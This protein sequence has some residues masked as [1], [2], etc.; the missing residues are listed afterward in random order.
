MYFAFILSER[1]TIAFSEEV[2]KV[3]EVYN[4]GDIIAF[5]CHM[6]SEDYVIKGSCEFMGRSPLPSCQI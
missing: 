6:I 1:I 4:S 5:A 2:L 3:C